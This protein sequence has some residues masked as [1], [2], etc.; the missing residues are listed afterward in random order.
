MNDSV[1]CALCDDRVYLDEPHTKLKSEPVGH[2]DPP[3]TYRA[4][5]D[6][7]EGLNKSIP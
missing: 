6:C 2:G 4:H 3:E 5:N 1:P 7:V